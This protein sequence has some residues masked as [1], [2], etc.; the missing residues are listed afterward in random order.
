MHNYG[1]SYSN[2]ANRL[3]CQA[4]VHGNFDPQTL[5]GALANPT[6]S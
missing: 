3:E 6:V 4:G 2:R 1:L 5:S